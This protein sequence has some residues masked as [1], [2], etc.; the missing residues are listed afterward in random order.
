MGQL[1]FD[2]SLVESM[3][4]LYNRRDVLAGGVSFMK[5]WTHNPVN[6]CSISDV[7]RVST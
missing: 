2:E 7:A 5:P 4:I 1:D 6:G 3:E